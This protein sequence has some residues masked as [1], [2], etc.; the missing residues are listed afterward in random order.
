VSATKF[1]YKITNEL[2]KKSVLS[3]S[4]LVCGVNYTPHKLN[5]ESTLVKLAHYSRFEPYSGMMESTESIKAGLNLLDGV[6]F[7]ETVRFNTFL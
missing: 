5:S 3:N 1:R 2:E 4:A 6:N 7:W